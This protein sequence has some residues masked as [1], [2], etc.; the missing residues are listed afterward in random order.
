MK[1]RVEITLGNE[2]MQTADEVRHAIEKS[3]RP[4]GSFK[5]IDGDTVAIRDTNGNTVGHWT[6]TA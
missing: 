3:L 6:V 1:F 2:A 5:L 4:H